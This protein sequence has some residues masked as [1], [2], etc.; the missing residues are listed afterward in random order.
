MC[1]LRYGECWQAT[2][3]YMTFEE[4]IKATQVPQDEWNLPTKLARCAKEL[5]VKVCVLFFEF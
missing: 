3:E 5:I 4:L 2:A 1:E